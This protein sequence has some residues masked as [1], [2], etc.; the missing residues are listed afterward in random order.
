M[1][2]QAVAL[3]ARQLAHA[4]LLAR[5]KSAASPAY[6]AHRAAPRSPTEVSEHERVTYDTLPLTLLE[7]LRRRP[8]SPLVR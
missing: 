1:R 3:S 2:A 6:L 4:A 7:L 5:K 8:I